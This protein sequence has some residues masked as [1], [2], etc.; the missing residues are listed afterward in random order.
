[1]RKTKLLLLTILLCVVGVVKA[2][3][4]TDKMV[5]SELTVVP[6]GSGDA[7]FTVSLEGSLKYTAYQLSLVLP[8]GLEVCY[9]DGY[10]DVYMLGSS[11]FYPR[12]GNSHS[13]GANVVDGVL[14]VTCFSSTNAEFSATSGEL[15]EVYVKASP[16]LKPG[17]VNIEV[18]DV[19]LV[20]VD[21]TKYE[22]ADYVSTS[23][24]AAA[25]STLSLKVSASNQ[26]GTCI[27]PF[28]YALP[29]DGS[30]EAYTCS[31][32]TA[33]ALLLEKADK[34]AAYTPYILY[35]ENGFSATISGEVDATKYP[36]G[37]IVKNGHLVG[38]VVQTELA[39]TTSYVMQNQGSGVKF[40]QVDPASPF[41]LAAGKCYVELPEGTASPSFRI[42]G[43][44]G[45]DN[46]QLT[47]DNSSVIYNVLGQRVNRMTSGHVYIVNGRKVVK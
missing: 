17:D 25:T 35:S 10:Y 13:L 15:F 43:T 46:G 14:N 20:T 12:R 24:K 22:P 18:K 16:Y 29:V 3:E 19:K 47:M 38:T 41:V 21:E 9:L 23:V 11:G 8:E 44:A 5:I 7:V 1:M 30:L 6:G 37:G 34:I 2:V 32:H 31:N 36:A 45:I 28:D 42:G 26:F 27:L 4:T 40:Y 39:E 33:D